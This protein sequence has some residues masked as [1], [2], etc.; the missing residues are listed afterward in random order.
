MS[1]KQFSDFRA[2]QGGEAEW[3]EWAGDFK[4]LMDTADE[5]MGEAMETV[6]KLN[7]AEKEVLS[8]SEIKNILIDESSGGEGDTEAAKKKYAHIEKVSK[9]LFRWIHLRTEG[10]AKMVVRLVTNSDGL[11]ALGLLHAKYSKKTVTRIMRLQAECMYPRAVKV[12]E[13][14]SMRSGNA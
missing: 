4:I 11:R 2:F 6:T 8:G 10:D 7:K 1:G 14:S 9:E 13:L 12:A 3:L 5:L